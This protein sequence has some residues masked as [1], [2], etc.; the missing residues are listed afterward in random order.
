M[1]C[2]LGA[3]EIFA[4]F[5]TKYACIPQ[6][7]ANWESCQYGKISLFFNPE[8][9]DFLTTLVILAYGSK[10]KYLFRHLFFLTVCFDWHNYYECYLNEDFIHCT[11]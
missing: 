1:I 6:P 7:L 11:I 5:G 4:S 8:E 2:F 3:H 9:G 10:V